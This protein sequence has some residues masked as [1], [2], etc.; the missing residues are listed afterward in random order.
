MH[1]C[2]P[3]GVRAVLLENYINLQDRIRIMAEP[4]GYPKFKDIKEKGSDAL[5][6]PGKSMY[7]FEL[8]EVKVFH[9]KNF[10]KFLYWYLTEEG[11]RASEDEGENDEKIETFYEE[12]RH[13]DG[14]MER[15]IWWRL[16]YNPEF[17][18]RPHTRYRYFLD[19]NIKNLFLKNTDTVVSGRKVKAQEGEVEIKAKLYIKIY[20]DEMKKNAIMNALYRFFRKRW[21]KHTFEGY[22]DDARIRVRKLQDSI[23]DFFNSATYE[24]DIKNFHLD[25]GL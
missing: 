3:A 9:M 1:C 18:G 12:W 19:I 16:M 7:D 22:R 5:G 24:D 8:K 23:K 4:F 10:Y 21:Y 25:K 17:H 11:W 14:T 2:P 6:N 15:R 20:D 13:A